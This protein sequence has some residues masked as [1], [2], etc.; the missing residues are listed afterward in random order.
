MRKLD[1]DEIQIPPGPRLGSIVVEVTNLSKGFGEKL[2]IDDLSF[3][4]PRNGIVGVV[5][6]NG[7]GKTSLLNSLS[8]FYRPQ[9]GSVRFE[10]TLLTGKSPADIARLGSARTFQNLALFDHLPVIDNVMVGRERFRR[11]GALAG[12]LWRGP[13]RREEQRSRE[14]CSEII[15]MIGLSKWRDQPAGVLSYGLRKRVELARALALEPKLLL[16]DEPVAGMNFEETAELAS[17]VVRARSELELTVVLVAH[18]LHLVMDLAERVLVLDFG[19]VLALD[20]PSVVR[21]NPAV[22]A[23][24]LGATDSEAIAEFDFPVDPAEMGRGAEDPVMTGARKAVS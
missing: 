1:F 6:P 20:V 5:G 16:L 18:D 24:Y 19:H 12:A 14:L 9:E 21:A 23:A 11:T 7:A 15:D 8:G 10:G 3:T 4:L 13:A 2:L 17:Y 22:I